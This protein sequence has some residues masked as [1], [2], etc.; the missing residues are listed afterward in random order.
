[1]AMMN[2]PLAGFNLYNLRVVV[3]DGSYHPVDSDQMAFEIAAK[4][5]Y[6]NACKL[7][8]ST[9]LEPVMKLEVST[10]D[11]YIGDVSSDL[12]KRRGHLEE[13]I[14]K[15]NSQVLKARVP[16]SEMFGYVT[17]L[18]SITSGRALSSLEFSHYAELPNELLEQ[19]L[20]KIK[21]YIV[22]V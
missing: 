19:V 8:K 21:G 13:V 16:L 12:N 2:G 9:L 4:V 10:P 3:K 18:R 6:R 7:M 1:M 15:I 5:G 17:S 22:K 14:A 11:E 20:Y